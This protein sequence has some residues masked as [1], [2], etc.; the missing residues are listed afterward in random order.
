ME[1][2]AF[3][4]FDTDFKS[5]RS[6][7]LVDP[8]RSPFMNER[9]DVRFEE[10]TF[11]DLC[12]SVQGLKVEARFKVM[13]IKTEQTKIEFHKRRLL[14]R[15]IG[16]LIKGNVDLE[17][18]ETV[19]GIL[20]NNGKWIF[21]EYIKS[22]SVWFYHQNKPQNYST[23]LSTRVA[24]AVVNIAVPDPTR[25]SVIDPC[26]G[27][28]TVLIEGL[29][30]GVKIVGSDINPLV[31]KGVRENIAHFGYRCNVTLADIRSV[32]GNY[33]VAII[34]MPYN[35]CSVLPQ[36]EQLEM[37]QQARRFAKRV[38]IVTVETIDEIIVESGFRII[39]RC[40]A[41]KGTFI[42]QIITCE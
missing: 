30:M 14:E 39:D 34:D 40:I 35:L 7:I 36:E 38:V 42:R 37:L 15:K 11:E 28:G 13:V 6:S 16:L 1:M 21:G 3:F 19:F 25:L 4:G 8:S 5:L 20:E 29:S 12:K 32:E 24:R 22:K 9:I 23:A 10:T 33:D 31:L 2:R 26:C 18:P 27:I 17:N 41:K